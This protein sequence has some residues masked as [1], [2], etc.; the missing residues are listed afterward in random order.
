VG[1]YQVAVEFAGFKSAVRTKIVLNVADVR[2]VDVQLETG[3]VSEQVSVEADA[4]AVKTIG[5][6]V[7][8]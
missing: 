2:A 7:S 5:G 3:V 8:A 6:E 4:L 1:T